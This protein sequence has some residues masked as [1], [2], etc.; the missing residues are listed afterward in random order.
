MPVPMTVAAALRTPGVDPVDARILLQHVLDV[1]HAALISHGERELDE[2]EAARYAALVARRRAGEPVAYL[3]GWREFY[4]RSFAVGPAVLIP[5]PE[6]ELLV[7]L[8]LER[9]CAN[10]APRV[11]DLGTGSGNVA[12][13]LALERPRAAVTAVD[14]CAAALAVA[15]ANAA[16]L[17]AVSMRLLNADWFSSLGSET[18]DLIVSNPPYVAEGDPHLAQGDLR[19]EPEQA[20]TSGVDGLDDIRRIVAAGR[21]FLVP[22]GWLLFEHGYDQ[23]PAARD[24]LTGAGYVDVCTRQDLAGLDRVSAGRRND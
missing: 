2:A 19:F 3:L 9:L 5:R 23:G 15:A 13:T 18:F 20:L 12:V 4:G 1:G 10:R 7:E 24:L 6:T 16:R 8:A 11:L 21:G 22:G 14:R 17:G